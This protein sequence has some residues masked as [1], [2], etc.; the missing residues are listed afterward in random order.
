MR[1]IEEIPGIVESHSDQYSEELKDY[2]LE[3]LDR[4][5]VDLIGITKEIEK[6][7]R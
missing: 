7:R 6:W 1:R 4:M 2:L 5:M 3:R